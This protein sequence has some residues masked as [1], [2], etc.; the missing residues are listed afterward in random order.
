MSSHITRIIVKIDKD[1]ETGTICL[2]GL[3]QGL[4]QVLKQVSLKLKCSAEKLVLLKGNLPLARIT[5]SQDI[6]KDDV[7]LVEETASPPSTPKRR[8]QRQAALVTPPK[9]AYAR[10]PSP[11]PEVQ[12]QPDEYYEYSVGT[13]VQKFFKGHDWFNGEITEIDL[14]SR[15]YTVMYDDGDEETFDFDAPEIENIVWRA[16]LHPLV[17]RPKVVKKKKAAP[18]SPKTTDQN[19]LAAAQPPTGE[20]PKKKR[21]VRRK[22]APAL[23]EEERSKLQCIEINVEDVEEY[24]INEEEMSQANVKSVIRQVRK[25][26]SGEGVTYKPWGSN[27]VFCPRPL[28]DL[29]EDFRHLREEAK[30]FESEYGQDKGHGW[31]LKH[32]LQ[33]LENYQ[34]YFYLNNRHSQSEDEYSQVEGPP[35]VVSMGS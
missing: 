33:K 11:E 10:I 34:L 19:K 3:S 6:E 20:P 4:S 32:P 1:Q 23:T 31:L 18:K 12:P 5:D 24:L 25:L 30:A 29:G 14:E 22:Q 2:V 7:L 17:N 8:N 15:L 21:K 27:V 35:V 16:R 28:K 9:E 13:K 26:Q